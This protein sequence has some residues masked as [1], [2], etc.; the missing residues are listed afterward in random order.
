MSIAGSLAL[1]TSGTWTPDI[2]RNPLTTQQLEPWRRGELEQSGV[3]KTRKLLIFPHAKNAEHGEIAPNWNVS[4]TRDSSFAQRSKSIG[5]VLP[6]MFMQLHAVKYARTPK[7]VPLV[8][9]S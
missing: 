5:S 1:D 9:R 3:L 7:L 8:F 2:L 6:K 4:G